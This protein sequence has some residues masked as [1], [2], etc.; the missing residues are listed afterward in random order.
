MTL[1]NECWARDLNIKNV[2][3]IP[4]AELLPDQW[5]LVNKLAQAD[6]KLRYVL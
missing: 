5:T 2:K 4:D 6:E 1:C 3:M